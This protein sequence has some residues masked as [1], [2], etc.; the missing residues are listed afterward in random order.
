[1]ATANNYTYG[2]VLNDMSFGESSKIIKVFTRDM[3]KISIM[4][5]GAKSSH[6]K[7]LSV[8][9]I[10]GVNEYLLKKGQSF[11]YI[12]EAKI[13]ETNFNIRNNYW[14]LIYASL[15]SEILEK[16]SVNEHSNKK[17]F[18]LFRKTLMLFNTT[19]DPI[20]LAMA[21]ELKY[22]TFIGYKP[23]LD[24]LEEN[25]FSV[26]EG[27]IDF[28]NSSSYKVTKS[29]L[30][31]LNSLLYNKLEDIEDLKIE[32]NTKKFL[33]KILIDYIKYN[34]EI[35]SFKSNKLFS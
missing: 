13:I 16:S 24:I 33:H 7:N 14:N 3:G 8:S 17:I 23:R 15:L 30:E 18:D 21:F 22:L 25:Y 6:S 26:R 35:S 29:D 9:Q 4:V 11:Y 34:L 31:Y 19:K 10:F 1:M 12:Q 2:I 27:V 5:K 20:G 28:Q 32:E